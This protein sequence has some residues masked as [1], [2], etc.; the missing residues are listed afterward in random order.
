MAFDTFR[1]VADACDDLRNVLNFIAPHAT[2]WRYLTP[3]RVGVVVDEPNG[4]KREISGDEL[5]RAYALQ[6]DAEPGTIADP[7]YRCPCCKA[8]VPYVEVDRETVVDHATRLSFSVR[9]F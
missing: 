7:A 4:S 9:V 3:E 5:N 6:A 1:P 2:V 8:T